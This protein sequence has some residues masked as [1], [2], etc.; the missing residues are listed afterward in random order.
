MKILDFV[1]L[2]LLALS[3]TPEQLFVLLVLQDSILYQDL[4]LVILVLLDSIW[5]LVVIVF[6]APMEPHLEIVQLLVS[7]FPILK[8]KKFSASQDSISIPLPILVSLVLQTLILSI[9]H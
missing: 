1:S 4:V 7:Q 6:L 3:L 8:T 5:K 2:V 9:V